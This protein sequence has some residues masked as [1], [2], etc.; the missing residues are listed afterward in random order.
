MI[1]SYI[2]GLSTSNLILGVIFIG[3]VDYPDPVFRQFLYFAP[4]IVAALIAIFAFKYSFDRMPT[5]KI[6][7][8]NGMIINETTEDKRNMCEV[9]LNVVKKKILYLLMNF[10][11]IILFFTE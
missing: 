2:C 11:L 10:S 5:I 9:F 3:V 7:M 6:K 1:Q 4:T 8:R